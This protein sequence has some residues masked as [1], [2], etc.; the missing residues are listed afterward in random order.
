MKQFRLYVCPQTR[1]IACCNKTGATGTGTTFTSSKSL[2]LSSIFY[3]CCAVPTSF[4]RRSLLKQTTLKR[5]SMAA[6]ER[7]LVNFICEASTERYGLPTSLFGERLVQLIFYLGFFIWLLHGG[8]PIRADSKR[9]YTL[10]FISRIFYT[11]RAPGR[12][13]VLITLNISL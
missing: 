6:R 12:R 9:V 3:K 11:L 1:L 8:I 13:I 7:V 4:M 2:R 10:L 5:G